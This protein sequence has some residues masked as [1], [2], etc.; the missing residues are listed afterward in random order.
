MNKGVKTLLV[1][2]PHPD[3]LEI[4]MGGTVAKAIKMGRQV[5][6]VVLTDGRRSQRSFDCSD[7][8][9]AKVRQQEVTA[10]ANMLGIKQLHC[11]ALSDLY[12]IENQQKLAKDLSNLL[13]EY[14]PQEIYLPH[15]TL[16]RHKSHQLGAKLSLDVINKLIDNKTLPQVTI[17]AYEA[18][19]LFSNWDL[20][21]DISKFVEIKRA[22]INCHQSQIT[23]IAYADGVLGL[24]RWR[25]VFSDPHKISSQAYVE[26]FIKLE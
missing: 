15:P 23:D 20:V 18:W 10:A 25:G 21:I 5:I 4:A 8:E 24:N 13:T 11:L 19:G 7:E 14:Q 3:D 16:D 6:S 1:I 26:V 2:S 17:W 12:S 22:A 9:M